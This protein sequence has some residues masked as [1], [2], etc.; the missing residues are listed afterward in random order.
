MST[1]VPWP[2]SS[3]LMLILYFIKFSA[4]QKWISNWIENKFADP[5]SNRMRHKRVGYLFR[6]HPLLLML[7][8]TIVATVLFEVQWMWLHTFFERR[9]AIYFQSKWKFISVPRKIDI[10]SFVH[11]TLVRN[12][13]NFW[14][15]W[16]TDHFD[17]R[18]IEKIYHLL[19]SFKFC[20]RK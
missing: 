17:S 13:I 20:S 1:W 2:F 10:D 12:S 6:F 4:T 11:D 3:V 18:E 7:F 15:I 19:K 16:S 9:S 5:I 14:S 8:I